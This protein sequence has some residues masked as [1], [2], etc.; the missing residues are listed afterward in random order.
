MKIFLDANVVFSACNENSNIHRFIKLVSAK[1][2]LITSQYAFE[3]ARRNIELKRSQWIAGLEI[4]SSLVVV[5]A[6]ARLI[7]DVNLAD[8]DKPI[9]GAA[10][11]HKCDYLLTGD[12]KDFGHLFGVTLEKV[13]VIDYLTL[14][15]LLNSN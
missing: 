13:T 7:I 3:E 1:H 14:A 9:L 6:D 8:K 11:A 10:I 12:K 4:I 15:I 5:V 2:Q